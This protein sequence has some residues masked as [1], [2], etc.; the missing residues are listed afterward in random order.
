MWLIIL[1]CVYS[2]LGSEYMNKYFSCHLP[3]FVVLSLLLP[4]NAMALS[5][6]EHKVNSYIN[7]PLSLSIMIKGVDPQDIANVIPTHAD[8][9]YYEYIG[10]EEPIEYGELAFDIKETEDGS[11][12]KVTTADIINNNFFNFILQ[13]DYQKQRIYREIGVPLE[14]EVVSEPVKE[15]D[16]VSV[17]AGVPIAVQP[18][19]EPVVEIVEPTLE[20]AINSESVEDLPFAV[21]EPVVIQSVV[22]APRVFVEPS[23][24]AKPAIK[25]WK[26]IV[27]PGDTLW[28][29]TSRF[30]G[31]YDYNI[32]QKLTSMFSSSPKAFIRGNMN[33]L[34]IGAVLTFPSYEE[35][36]S[37]ERDYARQ[38]YAEDLK[39]FELYR[40]NIRKR[41]KLTN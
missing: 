38:I 27:R 18:V 26:Y 11:F 30:F 8:T 22:E 17:Y 31:H 13:V 37:V 20:T 5:L 6:G 2:F 41:K 15:L 9:A 14:E 40:E 28:D 10:I 39:E 1:G 16:V 32:K 19:I 7:N 36:G 3:L 21:T 35:M 34:R 23:V 25:D 33:L 29:I 12:I 4:L 24:K